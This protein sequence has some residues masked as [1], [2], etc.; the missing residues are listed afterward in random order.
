M[1]EEDLTRLADALRGLAPDTAALNRD[2]LMYQAGRA[3]RPSPRAWQ[4]LAAATTTVAVALALTLWLRPEPQGT[5][6]ILVVEKTIPAPPQESPREP[7]PQQGESFVTTSPEL[8]IEPV[9]PD[10]RPY[11][12]R[13]QDQVLRWGLDGLP[14]RPPAPQRPPELRSF[15]N[16]LKSL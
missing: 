6:S 7:G 10:N 4:L 1:S 14:I 16:L 3:S 11:H 2:T 8:P 12:L 5:H 9:E 13:V 15:E